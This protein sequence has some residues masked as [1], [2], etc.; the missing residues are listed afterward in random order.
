MN[1]IHPE[2]MAETRIWHPDQGANPIFCNIPVV[3]LRLPPANFSNRFAVKH[4][5]HN[6]VHNITNLAVNS[7]RAHD[8]SMNRHF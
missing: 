5:N 4:T 2:G 8:L 7:T 6:Y 3:A 1:A